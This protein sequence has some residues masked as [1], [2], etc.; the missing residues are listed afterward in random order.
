MKTRSENGFLST[1]AILRPGGE[2]EAREALA[3]VRAGA[4]NR[5]N[6]GHTRSDPHGEA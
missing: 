2:W 4:M 1:A 3:N 5:T 6:I